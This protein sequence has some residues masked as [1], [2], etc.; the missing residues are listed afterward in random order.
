MMRTHRTQIILAVLAVV[1]TAAAALP[2]AQDGGSSPADL[3]ARREAQREKKRL[4]EWRKH[5]AEMERRFPAADF[6]APEP[7]D[8]AEREKRR[9]KGN[10]YNSRYGERLDELGGVD[11]RGHTT[12]WEVGLPALPVAR[13]R[14]V[15]IGRVTGARAFLSTDRTALYSEF[16]VSVE[17]VLKDDASAPLV[18][19]GVVVAER[20]GGQVRLPSGRVFLEHVSGQGMPQVGRR[21]VLFLARED[22]EA[23]VSVITGYELRDGR[24]ELLDDVNHIRRIARYKG[25]E[26]AAFLEDLKSAIAGQDVSPN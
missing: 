2:G 9:L 14:A 18:S 6:D 16:T 11:G 17:E 3:E 12:D 5:R 4:E 24:V 13:S 26:Q 22:D 7:D 19:D 23:N 10:K 20:A 8:P 21:Y 1:L 25:A 15:V